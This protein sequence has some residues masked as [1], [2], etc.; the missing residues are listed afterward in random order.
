MKEYTFILI[1]AYFT[2]LIFFASSQNLNIASSSQAY[3]NEPSP[4][5]NE[6]NLIK[7]WLKFFTFVPDFTN[8]DMPTKFDYNPAYQEQFSHGRTPD[9]SI[10]SQDQFGFFNIPSELSF[11]FVLSPKTLYVINARRV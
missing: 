10:K 1:S 11:F 3:R 9:F 7:G 4:E 2:I 6:A 5:S 8:N